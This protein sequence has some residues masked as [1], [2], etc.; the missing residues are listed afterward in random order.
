MVEASNDEEAH[1][2]GSGG[3]SSSHTFVKVG[4]GQRGQVDPANPDLFLGKAYY[5]LG[6]ARVAASFFVLERDR[7]GPETRP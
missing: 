2:R 7:R 4:G 3:A 5:A 6:P 1:V